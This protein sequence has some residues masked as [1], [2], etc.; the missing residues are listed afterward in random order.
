M[1]PTQLSIRGTNAARNFTLAEH[2]KRLRASYKDALCFAFGVAVVIGCF[3]W[4]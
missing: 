1:T 4:T 3:L 2:L